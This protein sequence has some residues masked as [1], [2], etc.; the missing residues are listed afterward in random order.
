MAVG[1]EADTRA[2]RL[3]A[4]LLAAFAPER[5]EVLDDSASHA[6]HSG[7]APGGETHFSVLMV[8]AALRGLGRVERQRRVHA[9][10]AGEF[11]GGLHA[12]SLSLRTPEEVAG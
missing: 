3:R 12:L 6:G 4:C 1:T 2:E 9:A 8:S 5:L 11:S 10:V 7:A